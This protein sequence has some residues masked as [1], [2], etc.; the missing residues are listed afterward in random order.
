[1]HFGLFEQVLLLNKEKLGLWID[2]AFNQP[3]TGDAIYF[4]VFSGNPF[5]ASPHGRQEYVNFIANRFS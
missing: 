3:R 5:H 2:K 4:D 1:V